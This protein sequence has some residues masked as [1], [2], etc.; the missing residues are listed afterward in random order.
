MKDSEIPTTTYQPWHP[1][2]DAQDLKTLGKL[3]EELGECQAA[4]MRCVIQGIDESEPRTGYANK[5]WLEDELADTMVNIDLTI[6]RF[7]LDVDRI[8]SRVN[9][10]KPLLMAWHSGA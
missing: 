1:M 4:A 6:S 8:K 10:K 5:L 7:N 3:G 2:S 9:A